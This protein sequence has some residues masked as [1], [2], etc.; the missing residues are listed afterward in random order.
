M[1]QGQPRGEEEIPSENRLLF[2]LLGFSVIGHIAVYAASGLNW[3]AS[4]ADLSDEWAIEVDV[5]MDGSASETALPEAKKAEEASVS[6]KILPQLPK[7][8]AIEK[9][10]K[11]EEVF[12][13]KVEKKTAK[14]KEKGVDEKTLESQVE[15]EKSDAAKKLKMADAL[16]RLAL[17]ELRNKEKFSD[18]KSA[19]KD[20]A[21]AKI[22]EAAKK[23][24]ARKSK[25]ALKK[26]HK[27]YGILLKKQ[28]LRH[29]KLPHTFTS[30]VASLKVVLSVVVNERGKLVSVDVRESSKDPVFDGYAIKAAKSGSPFERPPKSL[31]GRK[32]SVVF[33]P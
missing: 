24:A 9:D 6:K 31:A 29:Y 4:S 3:L 12:A 8:F 10:Q 32:I 16:K 22:K 33:T 7:S 21:L 17:E 28:I 18:E 2:L 23:E 11:E 27:K 5:G 26:K 25:A 15:K 20:D 30:S 13:E 1:A 19:P 14:E